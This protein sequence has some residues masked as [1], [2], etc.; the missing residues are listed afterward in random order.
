MVGKISSGVAGMSNNY[1]EFPIRGIGIC[2]LMLLLSVSLS[3]QEA[4]LDLRVKLYIEKGK[5]ENALITITRDGQ[6]YRVIDPNK[7]KYKLDLELNSNFVF[8]FTK[9]GYISKSVIVDTHVPKGREAEYFAEFLAEVTLE[10]QPEDQ[11]IT[12]SQPV[13]KIKY[14]VPAGD[15]DY[16]NDYTATAK[17]QQQ[18]DKERAIPKP[19]EPVPNPR[20]TPPAVPKTETPPSKPIPVAVKQPEYKPTPGLKKKEEPIPDPPSKPIVKN[21]EE[22]IIQKDRVKI[23]LV[24]VKIDGVEYLYKKEEYNW[25][26][27]YFYRDEKN[28]TESAFAKETE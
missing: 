13:G 9:M 5:L 18:K 7:G 16:D 24:T 6:P 25:G 28:I 21:K 27:V 1:R 26:G 22:R 23:T 3:A 10:P 19:K 2:I 12:Y 14:S 8:V 17:V 15:F 11:I 4:K 20:I